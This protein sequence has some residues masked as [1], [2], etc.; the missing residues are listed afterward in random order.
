MHQL[1]L[2]RLLDYNRLISNLLTYTIIKTMTNRTINWISSSQCAYFHCQ[3]KHH[4]CWK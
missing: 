1:V 4:H 2:Q 3:I